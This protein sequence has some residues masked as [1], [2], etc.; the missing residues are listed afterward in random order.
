MKNEESAMLVSS[1]RRFGEMV[2]ARDGRKNNESEMNFLP[3]HIS[4]F[5]TPHQYTNQRDIYPSNLTLG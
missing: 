1:K 2:G 3:R 5:G 4:T